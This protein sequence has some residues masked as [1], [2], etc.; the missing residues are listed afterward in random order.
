MLGL[1]EAVAQF[2]ITNGY[3]HTTG[4]DYYHEAFSNEQGKKGCFGKGCKVA[5]GYDLVGDDYKPH[6]P[7]S[8]PKPDSDPFDSCGKRSTGKNLEHVK[9]VCVHGLMVT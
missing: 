4:I 2:N 9:N 3:T 6:G 5:M 1:V 7:D 8:T